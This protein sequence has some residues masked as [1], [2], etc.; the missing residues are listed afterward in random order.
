MRYAN[1]YWQ[2]TET[3]QNYR[4]NIG[5]NLQFM[6]IKYLY[7]KMGIVDQVIELTVEEVKKY[8]GKEY[9][10]LPLNWSF[11]DPAWMDGDRISISPKI[12]PVFLAMT[13]GA[14]HDDCY[15]NEYNIAYLKR[16]EPIGC[17]DE[18][19]RDILRQYGIASYVNGCLTSI[20]PY[21]ESIERDTVFFADVP[22]RLKE[23]IPDT[24]YEKCRFVTHQKY[25]SKETS[26]N[27]IINDIN[28]QYDE[29]R[30]KA[31]LVV[32]SRLHA[33][34]PCMAMGIPVIFVKETIDE[35]FSW[36]DKYLTLYDVDK[37][38]KGEQKI[39]WNPAPVLY[40]SMKEK[41]INHA[42]Q[43]IQHVFEVN[44]AQCEI[45]EW[46]E[47]RNK[48]AYADF[49]KTLFRNFINVNKWIESKWDSNRNIKY[50]IWG[51]TNG[52][53]DFCNNIS[54]NWPKAKLNNVIDAYKTGEFRGISI[55]KFVDIQLENDE[56]LFVLAVGAVEEAKRLIEKGCI[57]ENRCYFIGDEFLSGKK[58]ARF[59]TPKQEGDL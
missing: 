15:F 14:R 11:F 16:Y 28:A 53:D 56:F 43:R 37:V 42:I 9:L 21:T 50:S 27:I 54:V 3:G 6:A 25:Y 39:E 57:S 19:T 30:R 41:I 23:Y 12:I 52:A 40:E 47:D 44:S 55:S 51:I 33:A 20:L 35:R 24:L 2:C 17:R 13:L 32:T 48:I 38:V 8:N 34:S 22:I 4:V 36:L 46:F 18:V 31:R 10:I 5:D 7:K 26:I 58:M 49:R 1:L 45:S 29:Y 59:D